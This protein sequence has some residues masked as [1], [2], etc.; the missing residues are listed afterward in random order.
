M[1]KCQILQ[2]VSVCLPDLQKT[3]CMWRYRS[4]GS[5]RRFCCANLPSLFTAS[6]PWKPLIFRC[7]PRHDHRHPSRWWGFSQ[8]ISCHVF[9]S[10][11]PSTTC[12]GCWL[13]LLWWCCKWRCFHPPWHLAATGFQ[14]IG[15]VKT[16]L[17]VRACAKYTW[18]VYISTC[19]FENNFNRS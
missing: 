13:L 3:F 19:L 12:M 14:W 1:S 16:Q 9:L 10:I 2:S 18:F 17:C 11:W 15:W 5:A 6:I 4:V 8:L 7:P